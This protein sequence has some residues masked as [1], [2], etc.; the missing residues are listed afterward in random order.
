MNGCTCE[1]GVQDRAAGSA[2]YSIDYLKALALFKLGSFNS[3]NESRSLLVALVLSGS[4]LPPPL[5]LGFVD[6]FIYCCVTR[7]KRQSR[8]SASV[9]A[10]RSRR[11]L[12]RHCSLFSPSSEQR[13]S[14]QTDDP[15]ARGWRYLRPSRSRVEGR[16]RVG[17]DCTITGS[18]AILRR[19]G[20]MY[21]RAPVNISAGWPR[22]R[23]AA[24]NQSRLR[25]GCARVTN[26]PGARNRSVR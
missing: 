21:M 6:L 3:A 13:K 8:A 4:Y 19:R 1:G 23:G 17:C 11:N 16:N 24:W 9:P 22:E 2:N 25:R 18:R 15:P 5:L 10:P 7:A 14:L 12:F 26:Y 20:D